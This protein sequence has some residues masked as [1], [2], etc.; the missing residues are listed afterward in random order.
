M[1]LSFLKANLVA[2][3]SSNSQDMRHVPWLP[4]KMVLKVC[5]CSKSANIYW[6]M[7][8]KMNNIHVLMDILNWHSTSNLYI[9]I[10]MF[11]SRCKTFT[12]L[13]V[14]TVPWGWATSTSANNV[15]CLLTF[16]WRW[17][18]IAMTLSAGVPPPG[19]SKTYV[20]YDV[21]LNIYIFIAIA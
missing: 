16:A 8:F 15:L 13:V 20:N 17:P 10:A 21:I 9:F 5:K 1:S 12:S 3:Y 2:P 18:R 7:F 14:Y 19:C 11:I 4:P 6:F